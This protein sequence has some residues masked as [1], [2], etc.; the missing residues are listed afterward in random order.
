MVPQ[1]LIWAGA[2]SV[3]HARAAVREAEPGLGLAVAVPVP[4]DP[5]PGQGIEDAGPV[6]GN[7]ASLQAG[8]GRPGAG[9]ADDGAAGGGERDL[10]QVHGKPGAAA[11][12]GRGGDR[13]GVPRYGAGEF[14]GDDPGGVLLGDQRRG[15]GAEHRPVDGPA[16][17]IADLASFGAVSDPIHRQW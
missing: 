4:G 14:G 8:G 2:V 12:A 15:S 16:S 9:R 3:G 1:T 7:Q 11:L 10:P 17:R 13:G 6:R 5:A